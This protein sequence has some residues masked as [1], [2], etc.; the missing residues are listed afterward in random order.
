MKEFAFNF[1]S[2]QRKVL[3]FC[4]LL[5][6]LPSLPCVVY[7][8]PS[9]PPSNLFRFII[10]FILENLK[11]L[12][13]LKDFVVC[14]YFSLNEFQDVIFYLGNEKDF[15]SQNKKTSTKIC[16]VEKSKDNKACDI[17]FV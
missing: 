8:L 4:E 12:E 5:S 17:F 10:S 7:C 16:C 15:H 14:F 13:L 1:R 2:D 11:S 9:P 3:S 6:F